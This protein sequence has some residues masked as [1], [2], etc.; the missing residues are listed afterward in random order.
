MQI[1]LLEDNPSIIDWLSTALGMAGHSVYPYHDGPSLLAYL[2]AGE[3]I[4]TS[5]PYDLLVV[6]LYLPGRM[7]GLDVINFIRKAIPPER[8]P[9]IVISAAS[10]SELDLLQAN[11]P[12]IPVLQKPYQLRRL[13]WWMKT[14]SSDPDESTV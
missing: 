13:L 1:G 12:D 2:F 11:H 6:D 8:L 9:I 7:S 4:P 5:I 14:L 10:L 3:N